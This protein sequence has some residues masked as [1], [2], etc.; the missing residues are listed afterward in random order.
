MDHFARLGLPAALD[1]EPATLDRAYFTAQRQWHPDRFVGH[2]PEERA[3]AS[4]EA[5]GLNDAYRTLKDP[6]SRAVYLAGLNG[7]ELPGDGKTIDDPD[8]LMEA[9]EAREALHEATTP[10]AVD[11]LAAQAR[12]DMQQAL[13]GLGTLFLRHDKAAIRKALLRLRYLDKFA[14]EARARRTNLQRVKA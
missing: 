5:A 4:T 12:Q 1:L 2:P 3:K 11:A 14:E 8:L 10:E 7:V 6:L 13:A 9:M